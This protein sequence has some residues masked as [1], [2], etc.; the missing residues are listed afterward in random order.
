MLGVLAQIGGSRKAR[1]RRLASMASNG[2]GSAAVV[3]T[4]TGQSGL[5]SLPWQQVP[6]FVPGVTSVDEYCQRLRFIKELCPAEYISYLGPRAALQVEG[7]AFQKVSRISPEKLKSENGV[8]FLVESLGGA[9][10]RT[11]VEEKFHFFEQAIFQVQQRSD[12][13][14]DSYISRHDAFFEELL[15]RQVSLEEVRAY[16]LLRH[17]RLAPEDKKK[18]VV[19]AQGDLR[20]AETVKAVRLLGS[21][22]STS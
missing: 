8:K 6:K 5:N 7:S 14:N 22:F 1:A 16:V 19:E 17:S 2:D 20:Y 3:S 9:W 18:V 10:G 21:R 11:A 15:T 12:E 4:A 13:S